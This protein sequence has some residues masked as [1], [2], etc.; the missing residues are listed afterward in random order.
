[1]IVN[2]IDVKLEI[3][4]NTQSENGSDELKWTRTNSINFDSFEQ[5][6]KYL[7]GSW[8]NRIRLNVVSLSTVDWF[9]FSLLAQRKFRILSNKGI[10]STIHLGYYITWID[11]Y[12]TETPIYI[13]A[14]VGNTP[15]FF[16]F[17]L[18]SF[19]LTIFKINK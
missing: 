2:W 19:V 9:S 13:H 8:H 5:A 4:S 7:P 12:S 18:R 11:K 14:F 6:Y 10:C 3:N 17:L 1:M 15:T 16:L